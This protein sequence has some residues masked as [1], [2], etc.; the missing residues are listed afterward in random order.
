MWVTIE[1]LPWLFNIPETLT[2]IPTN[3]NIRGLLNMAHI[4]EEQI[5]GWI[6]WFQPPPF[7]R[8]SNWRSIL[9]QSAC[10]GRGSLGILEPCSLSPGSWPRNQFSLLPIELICR[11]QTKPAELQ[12]FDFRLDSKRLWLVGS[13]DSSKS[14]PRPHLSLCLGFRPGQGSCSCWEH[15]GRAPIFFCGAAGFKL[16]VP[17]KE[18][19][20]TK[21]PIPAPP[22]L[23]RFRERKSTESGGAK[24]SPL[25]RFHNGGW[26]A[27]CVCVHSSVRA[28][29]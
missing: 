3:P 23:G 21:P 19:P 6:W 4:L 27:T 29:P 11:L 13:L 20:R 16:L 22:E 9:L 8:A 5:Q 10:L 2:T 18:K 26:E 28:Q 17:L 25:V 12:P 14:K 7:F 1:S 15:L 24:T